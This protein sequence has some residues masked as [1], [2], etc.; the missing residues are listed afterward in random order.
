MPVHNGS[1]NVKCQPYRKFMPPLVGWLGKEFKLSYTESMNS[2]FSQR[3]KENGGQ[4][5]E[6]KCKGESEE[7]NL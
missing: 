5:S 7:A 1:S 4:N 3:A 2:T 6:K